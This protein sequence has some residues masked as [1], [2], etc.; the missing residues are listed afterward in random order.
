MLRLIIGRSGTGKSHKILK[1]IS[2]MYHKNPSGK[3]I[4]LVPEQYSLEASDAFIEKMKHMGHMHM[5]VLSFSRIAYRVFLQKG[6]KGRTQIDDLGKTMLLYRLMA[7]YKNDLKI[8]G[9]LAGK[10]GFLTKIHQTISGF[11]RSNITSDHLQS[12]MEEHT[13]RL[14]NDKL[15]DITFLY[16]KFE[17][18]MEDVYID[19]E[20]VLKTLIDY[21][22]DMDFLNNSY[23]WVDGFNGFSEQE[24]TILSK[25]LT[26][27]KHMTMSITVA[28][29]FSQEMLSDSVLFEST[30]ITLN[31]M[32]DI[33]NKQN[34]DCK[35]INMKDMGGYLSSHQLICQW[36]YRAFSQPSIAAPTV[37]RADYPI[38]V[39]NY[40]N[41]YDEI[42]F[43]GRKIVSLV[44]DEQYRWRDIAVVL[45]DINIYKSHIKRE[46]T[47]MNIPYFM[48]EKKDVLSTPLVQYILSY[49]RFFSFGYQREDAISILKTGL[50]NLC[51]EECMYLENHLIDKGIHNHKWWK[52]WHKDSQELLSDEKFYNKEEILW[53]LY[54]IFLQQINNFRDNIKNAKT[55]YDISTVIFEHISEYGMYD[56][57]QEYA[58]N[59]Y[60]DKK[61]QYAHEAVAVYNGVLDVL[62]QMVSLIGDDEIALDEY[63]KLFETGVSVQKIAVIPPARD[64]VLIADID[65]SRSHDVKAIF[66]LGVNEIYLPKVPDDRDMFSDNEKRKLLDGGIDIPIS[67]DTTYAE[68]RLCLYQ[69]LCKASQQIFISYP[70][71]DT[72]G[73]QLKESFYINGFIK[74]GAKFI[75]I[76]EDNNISNNLDNQYEH[77]TSLNST[78]EIL[79]Q[80]QR[81]LRDKLSDDKFWKVLEKTYQNNNETYKL[82]EKILSAYDYDN[83]MPDLGE[84]WARD[85]YT[86]TL[87]GGFGRFEKYIQ[88]PFAHFISYGIRP[89]PRNIYEINLPDIGIVYHKVMEKFTAHLGNDTKKWQNLTDEQ[90]VKLISDIVEDE[91]LNHRH[92]IFG[93]LYSYQYM[94]RRMK[95]VASRSASVLLEQIRAGKFIPC[96]WE[97]EFSDDKPDAFAPIWFQL[98]DDRYLKLTGRVDRV[99]SMQIGDKSY[100]SIVDYKTGSKSWDLSDVYQGFSIQLVAYMDAILKNPERFNVGELLPAGVFYF[101]I[102]D[103]LIENDRVIDV[104][105]DKKI[106]SKLKLDGI[107][108]TQEDVLENI[109]NNLTSGTTSYIVPLGYKQDGQMTASSSVI[110]QHQFEALMEHVN[111]FLISTAHQ[112]YTGCIR[113]LPAYKNGRAVCEYCEYSGI[114]HFDLSFKSSEF[115]YIA[116]LD[117]KKVLEILDQ[118]DV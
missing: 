97:L 95:R 110:S 106:L 64:N 37:N 115:R 83:Y 55:V 114:C 84:Q 2:T 86:K 70:S 25:L 58:Q 20:D 32:K 113:P 96:S 67:S 61:W 90:A 21:I 74:A 13:E 72:Q 14:L 107:I 29:V 52:E 17:E 66:V 7:R 57:I 75:N 109:D 71:L 47:A 73:N 68:E 44:R 33:A 91:S 41:R 26:V 99:D 88:C 59:L 103:P 28:N 11:K 98:H 4:L 34:K 27:C 22:D 39:I 38:K 77:I 85:F 9:R 80:H 54:D 69:M 62:D 63:V 1:E 82:Y 24:Y 18:Q 46:F 65:R 45:T 100:I 105:V 3:Y 43:V 31:R 23:I 117:D 5:D 108:C 12:Y 112:I 42:A 78:L 60:N 111:N 94:V 6:K 101:H 15:Y 10:T 79:I 118:R 51:D 16:N 40:K 48:D 50:T 8:Y 30:A 87:S 36:A 56:K 104:S 19:E 76:G 35:I 92:N 81:R 102:D 49:L 53:I 116:K 89:K 93:D